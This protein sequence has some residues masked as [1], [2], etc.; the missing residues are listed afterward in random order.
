[1]PVVQHDVLLQLSFDI[2][3]ATGIPADDA[4]IVSEHLVN[5]HL[6]GHDSHGT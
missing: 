3:S 2:F 6:A 1:M 4:R 5:S